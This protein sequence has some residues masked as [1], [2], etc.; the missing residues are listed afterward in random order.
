MTTLIWGSIEGAETRKR[1][2]VNFRLVLAIIATHAATCVG[3]HS[4]GSFFLKK[5]KIPI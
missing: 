4:F 1:E 5:M 3:I 2:I